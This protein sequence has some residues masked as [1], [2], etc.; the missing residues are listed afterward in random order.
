M[1]VT[2]TPRLFEAAVRSIIRSMFVMSRNSQQ[3]DGERLL[4]TGEVSKRVGV[5]PTTIGRYVARRRFPK[6]LKVGKHRA[7]IESDVMRWLEQHA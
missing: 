7:W 1:R 2:P 4:S 5:H 3:T 6:P